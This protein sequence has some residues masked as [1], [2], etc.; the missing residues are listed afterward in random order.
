MAVRGRLGR[1]PLEPMFAQPGQ[2]LTFFYRLVEGLGMYR[3]TDVAEMTRT[4]ALVRAKETSTTE[5]YAINY[6]SPFIGMSFTINKSDRLLAGVELLVNWT[7]DDLER[8]FGDKYTKRTVNGQRLLEFKVKKE[9]GQKLTKKIIAV[10]DAGG[11][12]RSVRYTRGN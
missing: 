9:D 3:D 10:Q 6:L 2:A 5:D 11:I 1:S 8:A 4:A 12:V 7:I